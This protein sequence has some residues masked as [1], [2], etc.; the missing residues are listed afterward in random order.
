MTDRFVVTG[1]AGFI[2]SNIVKALNKRGIENIT[3]V[4]R[5][6]L[7]AK[8]KNLTSL[9]FSDYQDKAEFR[10]M[11]RKNDLGKIKTV[12]HMGACSSTT[13]M[14]ED[15]LKDNNFL[16]SK[17]LCEWCL[18]N[19]TRFIY[20]S[21]AATYGNGSLGYSD[22]DELCPKLSP[23]NP[24]GRSKQMFDL[25]VLENNLLNRVAGLKYFNVYGPGE[26]HKGDMRSVVNKAYSQVLNTGE[27]RLFK[28]YKPEYEDGKQERDFIYV[29]DAVDATLFFHDHPE[30]SGIF[31]C[32]TGK[33]RTWIDLA[34]AVFAAM[35]KTPKIVFIDMP[36]EIRDKYQ[37]HTQADMTKLRKAGYKTPFTELEDGVKD[38][39]RNYLSK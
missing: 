16:Y 25:W 6:N 3:V 22:N 26:D 29:A 20:A 24:Y 7:D 10:E 28:S 30:V 27:I 21:S 31:N 17:E 39:V 38:Y 34:N 11:V 19:T 5:L 18:K 13:E 36:E 2:G 32:G 9:K 15:Y 14:D 23:L 37:Y 1:G 12:F 35:E 8:K 33:A 4:D